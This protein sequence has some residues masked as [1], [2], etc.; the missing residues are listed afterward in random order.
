MLM[1]WPLYVRKAL[2]QFSGSELLRS[3]LSSA[4]RRSITPG[5]RTF[6]PVPLSSFSGK[7]SKFT[8]QA[9]GPSVSR[10]IHPGSNAKQPATEQRT[11][12]AEA[13]KQELH[14]EGLWRSVH[15]PR[16]V[17]ERKSLRPNYLQSPWGTRPRLRTVQPH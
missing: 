5:V 11:D 16:R 6:V 10:Q 8:L 15:R 14:G 17:V 3:S 9:D 13:T 12:L 4:N 7:R 1:F 2:F